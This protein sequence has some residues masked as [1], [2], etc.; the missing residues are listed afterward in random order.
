MS[1]GYFIDLFVY[2]DKYDETVTQDKKYFDCTFLKDFYPYK[3]NDVV[4][5]IILDYLDLSL[6]IDK[7]YYNV[8][9]TLDLS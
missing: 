4:E 9:W 8:S 1:S 2:S 6:I 7:N 5:V 3:K